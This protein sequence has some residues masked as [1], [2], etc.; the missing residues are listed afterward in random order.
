MRRVSRLP[1]WPRLDMTSRFADL[2]TTSLRLLARREYEEETLCST[3]HL[4]MKSFIFWEQKMDA[5]SD[6]IC[7]ATPHR[8][9]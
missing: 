9:K 5:P 2:T 6:V 8:E 4:D 1:L 7:L 3:P